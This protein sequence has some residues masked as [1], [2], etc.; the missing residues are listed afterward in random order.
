MKRDIACTN[1]VVLLVW[2][3]SSAHGSDR[4]W[5]KILVPPTAQV[6]QDFQN[7]PPEYGITM[8]WFWKGDMSETNIRRDLV[9]MH[10]RGIRAVML[11]PYYGLTGLE[12]LSPAWFE[13]VRYAVGQARDLGMRVWLMDE[14]CY[15]SGFVGGK[16]TRER[17]AQRMQVLVARTTGQSK[18]EVKPEYRTSPTRYIHAPGFTKDT[19]YSLFD[20]LDPQ[21]TRD[22]LADIHEHYKKSIGDEFGRTVL[23]FM[24][25]EPSFPGVPY[26]AGIYEE[27]QRR[28]GYDLRPHL[29]QLFLKSPTEESRRLR[30]DYWDVWTD[31]YRDNF[32]GV[33]AAWCAREKLEYLVHLC[34]EEDMPTLLALNGDY[35]KCVQPVQVP[36]IDAI[37][38]QIWPD[39]IADYAKLASSAAHLQ[40]RPRSFSESYAVY[41]RGLTVE[42]AKWV[43]DHHLVRGINLFQTMSF[44]SSREEFRPYFCPPDLNLSPQ[45]PHFAHLFAYGN[46]MSYLLSVGVPTATIGLYYPTTSV[47][48][49]DFEADRG[50]LTLARQLL[51]HQ[52]DFDFIDE[53]SL[54]KGLKLEQ[55]AL[56]NRSGQ[57]Y[58]TILIPPLK[59]ISAA[60]LA[61]L[62]AFA[63][64]GGQVIFL[65]RFPELVVARSYREAVAGPKEVP[66]GFLEP[67]VELTATVLSRLPAPDIVLQAGPAHT[68]PPSVKCLH[69]R[70]ADADVYFLFNEGMQALQV[71]ALL[72]GKGLPQYWDAETG[73]RW[74]AAEGS[75]K[76]N[77]A[78]LPM[79]LGPF[80]SR[81]I[82]LT[83]PRSPLE[84]AA[85][86]GSDLAETLPLDANWEFQLGYR[87]WNGTLKSWSAYGLASYSGTVTYRQRFDLSPS[88]LRK[89]ANSSLD[90]GEVRYSDKVRLNGQDLGTRAWRP[91]RWPVGKVL[92]EGTNVLEVEVTNTAANELA[93]SPQRLPEIERKGWLVN[94]YSRIYLKFDAEM[95]LSGQMGPVQLVWE[96]IHP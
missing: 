73:K 46:R 65:G 61:R 6:A 74:K 63:R 69:R 1:C 53:D 77:Y 81:I 11:W 13:R 88:A 29:A 66:W 79:K 14:G 8:W 38:R 85:L 30:A 22:F 23:G 80:E 84:T 37:W 24:G 82:V 34:G 42:Q 90:L 49:G 12:Y 4:P 5:Q 75:R 89:I 2:L 94:S 28:K 10:S 95:V 31:L 87:R 51:E 17:P 70:L 58:R 52:R 33:Q 56:V 55:G 54:Q 86:N 41:G 76:S 32:F 39:K 83:E 19:T 62:E 67:R 35:F 18:V 40:G 48:L 92:K 93:G 27:F 47:W 68:P 21:A 7:P 9:E 71:E 25:D 64:S 60:A 78:C 26:T 96:A 57:R 91:F 16:V 44:L 43:L 3:A 59:V 50:G 20:A 45:W 72:E 15:P 36:G